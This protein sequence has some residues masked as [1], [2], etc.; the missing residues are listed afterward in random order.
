[1]IFARILHNHQPGR[2]RF[3]ALAHLLDP[4]LV[5]SNF[6]NIWSN[7]E[8]VRLM[9]FIGCCGSLF[10]S[11]VQQGR[12]RRRSSIPELLEARCLLSAAVPTVV[13]DVYQFDS[14]V[15]TDPFDPEWN[16]EHLDVLWTDQAQ[17]GSLD[18]SSLTITQGPAN[19]FPVGQTSYNSAGHRKNLMG[20][21]CMPVCLDAGNSPATR[22]SA[23]S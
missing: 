21:T 11:T 12:R 5:C 9:T 20:A 23:Q 2:T 7:R 13:N 14:L 16:R 19:G 1:M 18:Y 22:L 3:L 4:S 10:R 17:N 8:R 6:R 15:R